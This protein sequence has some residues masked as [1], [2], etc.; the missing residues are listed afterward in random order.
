MPRA[1]WKNVVIADAPADAIKLVEG[2]VYF[3][4]DTVIRECLST[5]ETTT[6]CSWKGTASYYNVIAGSDVNRDAAWFYPNP[7]PAAHEIT[8]YVAFWRGVQVVS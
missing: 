6:Q 1:I 5:S 4:P 8:G 3:P 2:N 7:L